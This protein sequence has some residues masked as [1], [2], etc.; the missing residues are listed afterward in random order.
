MKTTFYIAIHTGK[1]YSAVEY[2]DAYN[3][4]LGDID[5]DGDLDMFVGTEAG[6]ILYYHNTASSAGGSASSRRPRT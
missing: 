4:W 2:T 6:S 1:D 5:M 3:K